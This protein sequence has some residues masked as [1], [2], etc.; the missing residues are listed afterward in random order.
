[1]S[2]LSLQD[3]LSLIGAEHLAC[4]LSFASVGP[5]PG[6]F[7]PYLIPCNVRNCSRSLQVNLRD[8]F[9]CIWGPNAYYPSHYP[10][11]QLSFN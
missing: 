1:M 8:F 7:R 10:H 2:A 6:G 11:F 4:K 5:L 9:C 3:L